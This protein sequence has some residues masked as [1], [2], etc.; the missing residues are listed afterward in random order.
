[1]IPGCDL[2]RCEERVV[3][4]LRYRLLQPSDLDLRRG[5]LGEVKNTFF[6]AGEL[7]DQPRL[8]DPAPPVEDD[9]PPAVFSPLLLK[10][11]GLGLA[12]DEIP[13]RD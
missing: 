9:Q 7:G 11:G 6:A 1:L 13:N 3:E 4:E 2:Q 5:V 10:E 8:A 12:V